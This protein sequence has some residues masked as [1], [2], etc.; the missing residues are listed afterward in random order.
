LNILLL[1][2]NQI[3][4]YFPSQSFFSRLSAK[5]GGK[6]SHISV[7]YNHELEFTSRILK[8]VSLYP[9]NYHREFDIYELK[10]PSS[11]IGE[12]AW[13]WALSTNIF[14]KWYDYRGLIAWFFNIISF[15]SAE[16]YFC[17]ELIDK[18]F[19]E[20]GVDL[21]ENIPHHLVSPFQITMSSKL[22]L[23]GK[24]IPQGF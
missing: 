23:V 21:L 9:I 17:S 10:E 11:F 13:A 12:F 24:N 19:Q 7:A 22:Q 2:K 16:R 5:I 8:G 14:E 6:Y 15:Q 1:K 3:I 20:G 18:F 4:A